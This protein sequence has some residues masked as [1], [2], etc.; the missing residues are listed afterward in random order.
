MSEKE[1]KKEAC[2]FFM[3][4]FGHLCLCVYLPGAVTV[5]FVLASVCSVYVD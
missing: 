3:F 4:L 2:F 5:T 1:A